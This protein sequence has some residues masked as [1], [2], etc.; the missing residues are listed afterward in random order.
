MVAGFSQ[1]RE[2]IGMK[3]RLKQ[4]VR[5]RRDD[6]WGGICYVP[7]RDDFFA[8]NKEVFSALELL[9]TEWATIDSKWESTF[10]AFAKLGI[11]ETALPTIP[12]G[13]YSGPSFL[14]EFPEIPTV[15]EP[16]VLN[17]FS[18][19]HCPLRCIYCHADDLMKEF[20]EDETET[21]LENVV[22]TASMVPAIVAVISGGDP[23]TRPKR[24]A[25]LI[26]RLAQQKAIVLDTSGVGNLEELLPTL[27][28][29][30]VHMRVSLDAISDVNDH[31]RPPN[32]EY[33][34]GKDISRLGAQYT[35]E[36]S[37][38]AGLNVTVQT[39]IS[40]RNENDSEWIDLRDWLVSKG[41]RHWVLHVAVKGGSARRI[42]NEAR[43]KLRG[44]GILPSKEIFPKLLRLVQDTAHRKLTLDIRCTDTDTTPNSV[45]LVGSKGDLYT[46]GYAKNG[47]VLLYSAGENRPDLIRSLWPHIDRFGHARRYLNWNPQFYEGHSIETI[48]YNVPLPNSGR[49]I[50]PSRLVETESK[51]EVRDVG[52]FKKIL[53]RE[54]FISRKTVLQRDEYFD[55]EDLV[56]SSLDNVV[57]LREEASELKI[58]Y[59]GPRVYTK[60]GK[61]SRIEFEVAAGKNVRGDLASKGLQ[62][63][64]FF[65]KRRT[66]YRRKDLDAIVAL[67]EIPE[68]GYYVEIEG[69]AE[70]SQKIEAALLPSLGKPERRNY[71]EVFLAFKALQGKDQKVIHGASFG[72]DKPSRRR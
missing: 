52:L 5:L 16:L 43:K 23:L 21:E 32:R 70:S 7:Q 46:E 27:I 3:V 48:C 10:A 17:C 69:P 63:T 13:A 49:S 8:A 29:H 1:E 34:K 65:E 64:W 9:K 19:A 57:R 67:D 18:T 42:E 47:K 22:S 40:A 30:Q 26:D 60:E 11:C 37:L 56:V 62:Q 66:E 31:V 38:E 41:V 61:Y 54:G 53:K 35:I 51:Y 55:T 39:V 50:T 45:F 33:V 24:A 6:L 20:R 71:K 4:G 2:S 36:R 28:K 68:I 15:S 72:S 14:G 25:Y 12:E 59:K 58:C 44:R